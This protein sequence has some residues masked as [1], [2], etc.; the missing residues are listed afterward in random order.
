MRQSVKKKEDD[1]LLKRITDDNYSKNQM[2]KEKK[3]DILEENNNFEKSP[4]SK[5]RML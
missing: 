3:Y 5:L 2:P 4:I 1:D